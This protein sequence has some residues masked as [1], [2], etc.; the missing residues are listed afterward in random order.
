MSAQR[1]RKEADSPGAP[2]RWKLTAAANRNPKA[3]IPDMDAKKKSA[4][5]I[6]LPPNNQLIDGGPFWDSEF[7]HGSAGPLSG[8]ALC[9]VLFP[10]LALRIPFK[11]I[12]SATNAI[13]A[14]ASRR[15]PSWTL[16]RSPI[17]KPKAI[18][19]TA[20]N[21]QLQGVSFL[22]FIQAPNTRKASRM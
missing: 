8:E 4:V 22:L 15:H 21:A 2:N 20:I 10:A 6:G 3:H 18:T 13:P 9:R 19:A 16:L 7:S 5:L 14:T 17:S 11:G 12:N 1:V